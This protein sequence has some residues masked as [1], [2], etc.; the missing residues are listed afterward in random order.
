MGMKHFRSCCAVFLAVLAL[1]AG[2]ASAEKT[3]LLTFTG[4]CTLGGKDEGRN[5]ETSFESVAKAQ[6]YDYFFANFRELFEQDDQTVINLE[7]VFSDNSWNE[8]K[9]THAFRGPKDLVAVL[10]GSSIEAAS[11]SNN[12]IKDYGTQGQ[13]STKKTLEENGIAWFQDYQYYLYKKDGVTV[14]FFALQNSVLYT[15]QTKFYETI[16]KARETDGADAVVVCW[17][18]G[19]EYKGYHNEDTE[20]RV[21]KLVENGVDL[22]IINHPHVV[23]GM[24]IYNNRSVFY[25]LGNFVFGGNP[26]I[27]GGKNSR[28]QLAISL[29]SIVVQARLTFSNEGKYLG[30][31]VTVYPAFSS[32][33]DPDYKPGDKPYP[34]NNYQPI[35][36]TPEQAAPVYQCIRRDSAGEIPEMKEKDGLAEIDFPYLPAFD[37]VM[38]PED[39]DADKT[40]AVIPEASSPKPARD[41][42]SHS[43]D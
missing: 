6:G 12:H 21:K 28:D 26:N 10:T 24:G 15:K 34:T 8:V 42:K 38:L 41:D 3:V 7:G 11:L 19:T 22:I 32:G 4:D 35:R 5:L 39:S 16:R 18:T 43:G 20:T 14:A 33:S 31:Q 29:Y 9:K 23:Q 30:Q 2:C 37:G 1:L 17:H 40:T 27:R 36:L 25:S 13:K